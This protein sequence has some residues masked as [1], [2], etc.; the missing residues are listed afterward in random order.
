MY[1]YRYCFILYTETIYGIIISRS[2]AVYLF[3]MERHN[4]SVYKNILHTLL[5]SPLSRTPP[6]GP[7]LTKTFTAC[8][9][10]IYHLWLS[11]DNL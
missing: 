8:I 3:Q 10:F 7:A 4:L 6:K 2:D 5:T 1:V 9:L 11:R